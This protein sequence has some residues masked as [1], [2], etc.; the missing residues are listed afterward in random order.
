MRIQIPRHICEMFCLKKSV[1]VDLTDSECQSLIKP[2]YQK[3]SEWAPESY[4]LPEGY[5]KRPGYWDNSNAP[6]LEKII[7]VLSLPFVEKGS[8]MAAAQVGKSEFANLFAC[9]TSFFRR[10]P[11][12]FVLPD[13]DL[14][15]DRSKRI[16]RLLKGSPALSSMLT[17]RVNDLSDREK[18]L[19]YT[20]IYFGHAT[21]PSS[22]SDKSVGLLV[23]D[24]VDK[25]KKYLKSQGSP[26][27]LALLR[28]STYEDVST[29]IFISTPSVV[30]GN[31]YQS[32]INSD[33]IFEFY[34]CCPSCEKFH[35]MAQVHF[36]CE[37]VLTSTKKKRLIKGWYQ[38]PYCDDKWDNYKRDTAV[39]NGGWFE[40]STRQDIDSVLEEVRLKGGPRISV[41]F[42]IPSWLSKL[43]TFEKIIK[44]YLDTDEGKK[45]EEYHAYRNNHEAM[46][47]ERI[48]EAVSEEFIRR[49]RVDD[50]EGI[51][52]ENTCSLIGTIDTH[53][54]H[55]WYDIRA[56]QYS[57]CG[58]RCLSI[59]NGMIATWKH[60]E[61]LMK[62]KYKDRFGSEHRV[63]MVVQDAM[64]HDTSKVYQKLLKYKGWWFPSKGEGQKAG[65]TTLY[66]FSNVN[67]RH[68]KKGSSSGGTLMHINVLRLKND[69]EEKLSISPLD[70]GAWLFHKDTPN[71]FLDHY[72]SEYYDPDEGR[73]VCRKNMDNHLYDCGVLALAIINYLGLYDRERPSGQSFSDEPDPFEGDEYK[74]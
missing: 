65:M 70:D 29:V 55:F 7:D 10:L 54:S 36:K 11:A 30:S 43:N 3:P 61:K 48:V 58:G 53:P 26:T 33:Y 41:G 20:S 72:R 66:R 52:P 71:E 13:S 67:P 57:D 73:F 50:P 5:S 25:Y 24:E 51:V 68:Y 64:G 37:F 59:K 56:V 28:T 2:E 46:P 49:L 74:W 4:Y 19:L 45:T 27:A 12:M 6:Y 69:L 38:C 31:I 34:C 18:R 21:S 47:Y 60:L 63:E 39:K 62:A 15:N 23:L 32:Y 40:L 22:I 17:G 1:K 8:V 35:V 16:N 9:W 42:K 14:E 44:A